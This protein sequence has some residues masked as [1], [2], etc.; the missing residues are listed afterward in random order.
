MR[1]SGVVARELF[2]C[3]SVCGIFPGQGLNPCPL[4]WQV[5]S[6][7]LYHQGSLRLP[8]FKLG[9]LCSHYWLLRVLYMFWVYVLYQISDLQVFSPRLWLIFSFSYQ[10]LFQKFKEQDFLCW[11]SST[12]HLFLYQLCFWQVLRNLCLI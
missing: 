3:S 4:H 6:K 12:Y 1:A 8:V 5:D 2:S 9:C 11:W 7:L 10:C